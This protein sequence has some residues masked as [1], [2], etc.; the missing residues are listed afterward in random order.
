MGT[1][2]DNETE[3]IRV[4][5]VDYFTAEVL[6]DSLVWPDVPMA[7]LNT[8]Y[9]GIGWG[10]LKAARKEGRCVAGVAAARRAVWEYVSP[11]TIVVGHSVHCDLN[12]L[13]W[14]HPVVVDSLLLAKAAKG[15][16]SSNSG[17]DDGQDGDEDGDGVSRNG[18]SV[19]ESD[20]ETP[21]SGGV[22]LDKKEPSGAKK[23][24]NKRKRGGD[25]S[26]KKLAMEKL[27]RAIQGRRGHDSLEDALAARDLV[28]G[29]ISKEI[30]SLEEVWH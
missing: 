7:S 30:H 25:F 17:G 11:G 6:V 13:R 16:A 14:I 28:H 4:T 18:T 3:L 27:G 1:A 29:Y 9:S 8:R 22:R 23:K 10:T 24:K 15:A 20:E 2:F 26:L 19:L 12:V 21:G 5:L